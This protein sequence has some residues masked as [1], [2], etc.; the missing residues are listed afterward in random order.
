MNQELLKKARAA[1]TPEELLQLAHENGMSDFTEEN[2]KAYFEAM[3][4]SGELSDDEL[5]SAAGGYKSKDG[6]RVV[7]KGMDCPI[8]AP[9]GWK[10]KVCK[11]V[12]GKCTCGRPMLNSTEDALN[13]TANFNKQGICGTCDYCSYDSGTWHCNNAKANWA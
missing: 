9:A 10:C 1:K 7:S 12:E 13:I 2:A 5:E 3:H 6:R 8:K 4:R 11:Q